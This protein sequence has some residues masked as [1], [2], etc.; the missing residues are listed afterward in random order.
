MNSDTEERDINEN[1]GRQDPCYEMED[2]R[3]ASEMLVAGDQTRRS[4]SGHGGS[5]PRSDW[6]L[7]A[8]IL[9]LL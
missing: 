6:G 7:K 2:L 3:L 9:A 8:G 4:L 1:E 5:S